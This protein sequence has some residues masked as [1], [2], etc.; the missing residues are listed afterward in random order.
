MR[1]I[2]RTHKTTQKRKCSFCGALNDL[3]T[4]TCNKC[5]AS[6]TGDEPETDVT[7]NFEETTT[8]TETSMEDSNFVISTQNSLRTIIGLAAAIL[9]VVILIPV[10]LH[11]TSSDKNTPKQEP[12]FYTAV[13]K[14]WEYKVSI[15]EYVNETGLKSDIEP[16]SE[17][18]NV[19]AHQVMQPNGWYKTEYTYDLA[20]WRTVR[21]ET[22]KGEDELPTLKEYTPKDGEKIM[23]TSTPQYSVTFKTPSGGEKTVNMSESEWNNIIIGHEYSEIK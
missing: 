23:A 12:T 11:F 18:T 9:I 1:K 14:Q 22:I 2:T 7:T 8:S 17:A 15:G 10:A 4:T 19:E 20:G 16:P 13:S 5:G 3:D 6:R 21:T